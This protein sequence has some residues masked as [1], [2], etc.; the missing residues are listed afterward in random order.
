MHYKWKNEHVQV[1]I[2]EDQDVLTIQGKVNNRNQFE[3]VMLFAASPIDRMTNYSGSGLAFPNS[4]IAFEA[5]PNIH[6]VEQNG[7]INTIFRKPNSYY[8][9]DTYVKVKP[10]L[11]LKL[12]MPNK[13][14]PI[15]MRFE[16]EDNL[17]LRS[18]FY[19]PERT[20]PEFYH[21][22]AEILGVTSQESILRKIEEVKIKYGCA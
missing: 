14:E 18:V 4:S 21:K 2:Q 9:N 11:F 6:Y 15:L 5:T 3:E 12:T 8:A 22:K 19:R 10:S 16:L 7:M 20:G 1:Y 17:P 13:E